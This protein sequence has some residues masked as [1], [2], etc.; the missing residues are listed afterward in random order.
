MCGRIA[1][2]RLFLIRG[3]RIRKIGAI[4]NPGTPSTTKCY[5]RTQ[6]GGFVPG[7]NRRPIKT[8]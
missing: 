6:G 2:T 1:G 3:T 8:A 4:P 5:A 7:Q